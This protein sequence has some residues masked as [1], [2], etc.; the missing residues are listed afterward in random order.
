MQEERANLEMLAKERLRSYSL[1]LAL[2]GTV[3]SGRIF[4]GISEQRSAALKKSA[5]PR[6]TVLSCSLAKHLQ[7]KFTMNICLS[8]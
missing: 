4:D 3:L 2:D 8:N 5:F 1:R 7:C 6:Y